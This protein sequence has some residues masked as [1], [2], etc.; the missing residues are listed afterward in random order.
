MKKL[1]TYALIIVA[2]ILTVAP[3]QAQDTIFTTAQ[4][5]VQKL[6]AQ[7]KLPAEFLDKTNFSSDDPLLSGVE[8]LRLYE[9]IFDILIDDGILTSEEVEEIKNK[10]STS[11]GLK[12]GG[13]NLKVL[14]A[15]LRELS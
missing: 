5:T 9:D 3:A 1:L 14:G 12:I 2:A 7:D 4:D 15:E 10:A 13:Y 8:V 11:G 6:V